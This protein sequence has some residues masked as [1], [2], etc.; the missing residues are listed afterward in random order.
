MRVREEQCDEAVGRRLPVIKALCFLPTVLARKIEA[1][2]RRALQ[3]FVE[4]AVDT[5]RED[6]ARTGRVVRRHGDAA[7]K[8]FDHH[9]AETVVLPVHAARACAEALQQSR[10]ELGVAIEGIAGG[11][12]V[13]GGIGSP[14]TQ[15]IG[16][17]LNGTPSGDAF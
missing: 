16:V 12:A 13:F 9:Q 2:E 8:G 5:G 10:P 4:V 6:V 1:F 15:A 7:R 17:G 14:I 11:S 3:V